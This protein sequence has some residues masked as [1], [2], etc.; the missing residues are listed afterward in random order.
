MLYRVHLAISGIDMNID[1][2]SCNDD[3]TIV[4]HFIQSL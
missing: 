4:V 2:V 3:N 1:R